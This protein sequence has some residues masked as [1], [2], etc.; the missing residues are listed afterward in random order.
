MTADLLTA[1][2]EHQELKLEAPSVAKKKPEEVVNPAVMP[3][4]NTCVAPLAPSITERRFLLLKVLNLISEFK[5]PE[6]I[7]DVMM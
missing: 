4:N 7:A 5:I 6:L 2:S 1:I 3:G